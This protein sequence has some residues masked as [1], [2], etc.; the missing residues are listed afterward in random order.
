MFSFGIFIVIIMFLN[1]V[2]WTKL[3]TQLGNG[4]IFLYKYVV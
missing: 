2:Y 1:N 3:I 4:S